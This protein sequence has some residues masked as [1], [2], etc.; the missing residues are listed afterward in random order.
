[1]VQHIYAFMCYFSTADSVAR[2]CH[3]TWGKVDRGC[4]TFSSFCQHNSRR[5]S[6]CVEQLQRGGQFQFL[7]HARQHGK[8]PAQF[9]SWGVRVNSSKKSVTE[10]FSFQQRRH[11]TFFAPSLHPPGTPQ[12]LGAST[13]QRRVK[14]D[15]VQ[16]EALQ[17]LKR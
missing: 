9:R 15:P 13:R 7:H 3:H 6:R 11:D 5:A 1:M 17:D 10:D 8:R 4:V 12:R 2:G 16:L 14:F